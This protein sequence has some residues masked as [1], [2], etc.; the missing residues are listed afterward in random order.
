[1]CK[2]LVAI[3]DESKG[4]WI[5]QMVGSGIGTAQNILVVILCVPPKFAG[6]GPKMPSTKSP[7]ATILTRRESLISRRGTSPTEEKAGPVDTILFLML[8]I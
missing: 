7:Q 1:M 8:N 5:E 4:L 3:A 2:F 6:T